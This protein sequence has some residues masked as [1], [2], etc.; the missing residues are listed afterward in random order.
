MTDQHLEL[1]DTPWA[2]LYTWRIIWPRNPGPTQPYLSE[3]RPTDN[4]HALAGWLLHLPW[5]RNPLPM[6]KARHG[7]WQADA[8]AVR[9][10]RELATY[11]AGKIPAQERIWVRLDWEVTDRRDRDEDNLVRCMKA[12]VDGIRIAGVV[13]KD[14]GLHVRRLMPTI[15]YAPRSATRPRA[16][17]R[18]WILTTN[19]ADRERP[20]H[21]T[22]AQ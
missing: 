9:N 5:E 3:L 12:L 10:V 16:F 21:G 8:R 17:M 13:P 15:N 11:L 18:L 4:E 14:T 19:P 1:E 22:P 7:S 6:N 2:E 20:T